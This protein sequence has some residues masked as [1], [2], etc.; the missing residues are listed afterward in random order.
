LDHGAEGLALVPTTE[1]SDRD[2]ALALD[3]GLTAS[4]ARGP[5]IAPPRPISDHPSPS[6]CT[7]LETDSG[8][9]AFVTLV[10]VQI[11]DDRVSEHVLG[12]SPYSRAVVSGSHPL[13]VRLEF[14]EQTEGSVADAHA[15]CSDRTRSLVV[16]LEQ[17][18]DAI[19]LDGHLP[20]FRRRRGSVNRVCRPPSSQ[21][22]EASTRQRETR[23]MR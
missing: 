23:D 21:S 17:A 22:P 20:S 15:P 11:D 13:E 8:F 2:R 12:L 4:A 16:T 7:R 14:A 5:A 10:I 19:R 9:V 6:D 3:R 18:A 1:A